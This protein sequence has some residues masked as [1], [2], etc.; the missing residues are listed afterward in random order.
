MTAPSDLTMKPV[1]K[2]GIA[3]EQIDHELFLYPAQS[4]QVHV[5]NSGAALI[6][7]LCDGGRDMGSI[8]SELATRFNLPEQQ[9]LNDVQQTVA[10]L[11]ALGL[12][13]PVQ[14]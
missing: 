7:M 14:N 5:L 10:Q 9:T 11:Q 12:L 4:D 6:W 8:A 3:E 13:E 2:N 1:K